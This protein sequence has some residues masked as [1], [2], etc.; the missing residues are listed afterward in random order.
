MPTTTIDEEPASSLNLEYIHFPGTNR[1]IVCNTSLGKPRVLVLAVRRHPIF[2][3]IHDLVNPSGKATSAIIAK[4]Y[5]WQNMRC[6]ML[7]WAK[8]CQT[9]ATSKIVM[10]TKPPVPPIP[11]P[12]ECFQH[13]HVDIVGP[14]Q[15]NQRCKYLLTMIDWT[16]RWPEA[17]PIKDKTSYTILQMFLGTWVSRFGIPY[18]VTSDRGDQFTS[19]AW[20]KSLSRLGINVSTTTAYHPQ[21]NGIVERFHRTLKNALLS[22]VTS[23]KSW[24]RSL[25][26][27]L[28]GLR[29]S[30][31]LDTAT[32]SILAAEVVFG[33]RA[34]ASKTN[35]L[36]RQCS[37]AEQLELARSNVAAF[38]P[39]SL[40]L[41]C[42]KHSPFITKSLCTAEFVYVRDDRL[43]KPSLD[44]STPAPSGSKT[45]TGTTTPSSW[46]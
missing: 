37:T 26:W 9:C 38:S 45:K 5:M 40:D 3:V 29:N 11:V 21:A 34:F 42:F 24:T 15:P 10:H 6:D 13:I 30:P 33:S 19:E 46:I 36:W 31:R 16:T 27:V 17:V 7:R 28:L 23:S 35:N 44:P 22:A 4:S 8:E 18:T 14:F 1:Q 2:S 25:P 12:P 43:G 39:E 32:H 41:R 20:R